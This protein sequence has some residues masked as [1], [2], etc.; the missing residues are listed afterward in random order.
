VISTESNDAS[1]AGHNDHSVIERCGPSIQF[2]ELG[3]GSRQRVGVLA[4]IPPLLREMGADPEIVLARAGLAPL[5]LATPDGTIPYLSAARLLHHCVESTGCAHFGL[6][7]GQR[8]KFSHHGKL[9][10]LMRHSR[11]VSDALRAQSAYHR[12]HSDAGSTFVLT[13][14]ST[15]ALGYAI[16]GE[17][18]PYQDQIHDLAIASTHNLLRELCGPRWSPREVVLSRPEPDDHTPYRKAFQ[19]TVRFDYEHSAVWFSSDWGARKLPGADPQ[20]G[21]ELAAAI[22][23]AISEE[24]VSKLYRLLRILLLAGKSSGDDLAH[25]VS[26]H[27]RTLNRRLRLQGT[28]FQRMLDEVRFETARQ[29]LAHTNTSID[30]IAGALCYGEV[31]AFAHAFRR[32]SGTTPARWRNTNGGH[33]PADAR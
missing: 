15:M 6:L 11:S 22:E 7:V 4:E 18:V 31:S 26:L 27:R 24:L 19:T 3:D 23:S 9:G 14:D 17:G 32:W 29:L 5:A 28:T 13:S 8:W 2:L 10:Q 33:R 25:A 1:D 20:R 12:L 16:Y 21:Q 30:Q